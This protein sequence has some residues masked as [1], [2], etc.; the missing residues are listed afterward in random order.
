MLLQL[1]DGN[2]ELYSFQR[3]V[4]GVRDELATESR[5]S[6]RVSTQRVWIECILLDDS[7]CLPVPR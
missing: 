5:N 6:H 7:V 1:D 4:E 3:G 2:S